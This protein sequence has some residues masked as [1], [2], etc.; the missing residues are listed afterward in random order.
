[1]KRRD[2][3][4]ASC[5]AGLAP[6][7][8]LAAAQGAG[9]RAE[10]Q[11][12][13]LILYRLASAAKQKLL[14]D[15]LREAAV[16]ALNRI[17]VGPVGVFKM[18][19]GDDPSMYVLL[20][21]DSVE[22]VVTVVERLQGDE[23]FLSAGRAF[24]EAPPS[25]PAYLRMESSLLVAFDGAAR[26]ELP[27][28]KKTRVFQ[29]RTYESHN[30]ERAQKKIAMFN[31]GGEL[32]IFRRTGMPPVFF[33]ETLI[34]AKMP[35]LT[36]MLGFDDME[37]CDRGWASFRNDPAWLRLKGDPAY[38]DTVSNITNLL[39]RPAASSQV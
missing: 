26:L 2:F 23:Q 22:S 24:L 30:I 28:K 35:N 13:Q 19:E 33:G 9:D 31:E 1:M 5:L 36:Y 16:A 14:D 37:A 17:G 34:G 27:T 4:T 11:Y 8:G 32:E 25:D 29:L 3:L 20:P 12:Y 15:F 10:K 21:H 7:G 39:L 18:A 38:R 6:L